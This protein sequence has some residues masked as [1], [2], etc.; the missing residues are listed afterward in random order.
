[1]SSV[2]KHR[3]QQRHWLVVCLVLASVLYR[4]LIPAGFMPATGEAAQHGAMLMVCPHGEMGMHAHDGHGSGGASIEQCPFGAAAG[5][6]VPGVKVA[7]SF[8]QDRFH[9]RPDWA[10]VA[11]DGIAPQLLPPARAPPAVS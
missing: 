5:P 9:F 4:G 6:A 1:M 2:L 3:H 8:S 10:A 11:H 7:F